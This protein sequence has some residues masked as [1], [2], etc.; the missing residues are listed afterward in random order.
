METLMVCVVTKRECDFSWGFL[1]KS[2]LAVLGDARGSGSQAGEHW[3]NGE[4]F[5]EFHPLKKEFGKTWVI[6]FVC[7][8]LNLKTWESESTWTW[9][10][11][12]SSFFWS[13]FLARRSTTQQWSRVKP[14]A[15]RRM[16]QLIPAQMTQL[17]PVTMAMPPAPTMMLIPVAMVVKMPPSPASTAIPSSESGSEGG[18][19]MGWLGWCVAAFSWRG[20]VMIRK[21]YYFFQKKIDALKIDGCFCF[22]E[23]L[24]A[25]F[26][27]D[28][29]GACF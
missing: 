4:V 3:Q 22:W 7:F 17:I 29:L 23:F 28:A 26:R 2:T 27:V 10:D 20:N 1:W 13:C 16:M 19:G 18:D 24:F 6:P 12:L 21:W 14:F 9:L 15:F 8:P 5:L 11:F 25:C